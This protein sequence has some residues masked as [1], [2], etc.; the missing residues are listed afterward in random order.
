MSDRTVSSINAHQ[1]TGC[2]LCVVQCP[3]KCI[4][5]SPDKEGFLFPVVDENQCVN[6][7][8]CLKECPA[9]SSSDFFAYQGPRTYYSAIIKDKDLLLKSSSGGVFG[10]LANRVIAEGGYVCGCVYD[11]EMNAV[12]TVTNDWNCVMRMFGSKYV[13]SSAYNCYGKIE[14]LLLDGQKVLFSGTACQ[15]AALR[16]F[17]NI[18]YSNLICVEIL[19]HGVPSPGLFKKYVKHLEKKLSGQVLD[20]QFR[21]KEKHGW[22]SEHRT[23][24]VYKKQGKVKKFRP[25]LPA[26]FS[27]FFY[28]LNLRESC[29]QCKYAKIERIA[30]LTIGDFWGAFAKYGKIFNEGISV[31][32]VNSPLGYDIIK[33]IQNQFDFL[34]VLPEAQAIRSNDNFLHPVKRPREREYFY[35]DLKKNG[36]CGLWKKTYFT[37]TYRRK[38]LAS[39]YGALVPAKIR[40][41]LHRRKKR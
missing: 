27:A 39:I 23:C 16:K 24:V 20:V 38:T 31:I 41:A 12:H 2:G 6:C 21:N 3:R 22:G 34:E 36:Y 35:K 9:I 17:L 33:E 37:K 30:D 29:Y 7:G 26:Y 5:M 8:F 28:G 13:Q 4:E 14:K 32:S 40:Y 1:C 19:C 11:E 10:A 25:L 15:I 18:G